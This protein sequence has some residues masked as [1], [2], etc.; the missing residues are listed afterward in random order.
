MAE[1]HA[2]SGREL[3]VRFTGVGALLASLSGTSFDLEVAGLVVHK[4]AE[5]EM[6]RSRQQELRPVQFWLRT[7][8]DLAEMEQ[9]PVATCSTGFLVVV[10]SRYDLPG[11]SGS[12]EFF[13][14]AARTV[15]TAGSA[16]TAVGLSSTDA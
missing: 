5:R 9:R 1:K 10:S 4:K 12:G 2:L 16:W 15:K 6:L 13:E 7:V 3:K 14:R 11:C 8:D